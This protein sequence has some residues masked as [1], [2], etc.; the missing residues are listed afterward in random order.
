M[1]TI[2]LTI[3]TFHIIGIAPHLGWRVANAK[4]RCRRRRY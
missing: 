1:R 4:N 3:G 2:P